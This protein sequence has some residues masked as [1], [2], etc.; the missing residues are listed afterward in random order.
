MSAKAGES[1]VLHFTVTSQPP[2]P[3]NV[4]H[5]LTHEDGSTAT[6]RFKVDHNSITFREVRTSDSGFYTIRCRNGADLVG[7][8]TLELEVTASKCR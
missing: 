3:S 8:E 5:T 2:L 7:K 1:P 6:K 4:Q